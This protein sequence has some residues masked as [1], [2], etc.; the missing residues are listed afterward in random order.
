LRQA[1]DADR[2]VFDAVV[3]VDLGGRG[4]RELTLDGDTVWGIAGPPED[5]TVDFELWRL[6]ATALLPAARLRG[7]RVTLLPT[8]SEGLAIIDGRAFVFIDGDEG[9]PECV[10]P[11]RYVT[12]DLGR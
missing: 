11:A 10:T 7:E 9:E 4:V 12:I 6:P 1:G 8:S 5:A 3:L 2:F